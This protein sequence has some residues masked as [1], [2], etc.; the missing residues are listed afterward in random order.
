[1]STEKD[2]D[3]SELINVLKIIAIELRRIRQAINDGHDKTSSPHR[4]EP[5]DALERELGP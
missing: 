4:Y 1:M 5:C 2:Q 3:L